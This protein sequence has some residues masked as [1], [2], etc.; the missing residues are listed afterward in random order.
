MTCVLARVDGLI[1][2][3]FEITSFEKEENP[4]AAEN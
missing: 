1:T 3:Y 4:R 2:I